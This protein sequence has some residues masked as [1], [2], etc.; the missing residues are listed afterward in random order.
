M[1]STASR[2]TKLLWVRGACVHRMKK[3][4]DRQAPTCSWLNDVK[5][6]SACLPSRTIPASRH[7]PLVQLGADWGCGCQTSASDAYHQD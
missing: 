3:G 6:L 1:V 5:Q 4:P 7:R 2:N